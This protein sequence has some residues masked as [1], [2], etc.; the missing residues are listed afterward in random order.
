MPHYRFDLTNT[1]EPVVV[2]LPDD[3]AAERR[4]DALADLELYAGHSRI[5][6]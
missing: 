3:T 4:A 1:D 5:D 2:E 6:A